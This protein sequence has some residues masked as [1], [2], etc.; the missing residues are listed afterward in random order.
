MVMAAMKLKD[1]YSLEKSYEKPEQR[2]KKQRHHF[3]DKDPYSQSYVLFCF[4]SIVLDVK[5]GT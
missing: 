2:I 5:V 3:A 1:S 4:F